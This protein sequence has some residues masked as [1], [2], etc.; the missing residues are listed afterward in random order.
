MAR[1]QSPPILSQIRVARSY[2]EQ[3]AALRALKD[4][5]VGHVQRKEKWIE[6]GI[7]EPLVKTLQAIRSPGSRNGDESQSN[8]G[9]PRPLADS[10]RVRL[11]SL[12]LIASFASGKWNGML[13]CCDEESVY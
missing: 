2:S 7:L 3:T 12:E 13:R 1:I 6:N 11:L 10:E 5:I 9:Q 4:D 8:T